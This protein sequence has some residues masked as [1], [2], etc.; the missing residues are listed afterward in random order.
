MP[1]QSENL[2]ATAAHLVHFSLHESRYTFD[3]DI[4]TFDHQL[5][6][7]NACTPDLVRFER[8]DLRL[9]ALSGYRKRFGERSA[10]LFEVIQYPKAR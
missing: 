6:A 3:S 8:Y 10:N 7:G 4:L 5:I 2:L 9:P 1:G